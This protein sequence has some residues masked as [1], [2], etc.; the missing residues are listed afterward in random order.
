MSDCGPRSSAPGPW[1]CETC[2]RVYPYP[3]RVECYGKPPEL[4]ADEPPPVALLERL[5]R[6]L[7]CPQC[8]QGDGAPYCLR[9][10][11]TSAESLCELRGRFHTRV[12]TGKPECPRQALPR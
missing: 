9:D 10:R 11:F 8:H 1:Q 4:P 7:A 5:K 3:L 6:C 2:G 12:R